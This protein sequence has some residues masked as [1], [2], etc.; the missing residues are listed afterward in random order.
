MKVLL[1][2]ATGFIGSAIL[3]QLIQRGDKVRVLVRPNSNQKNFQSQLI[4]NNSDTSR[5]FGGTGSSF[6]NGA[7]GTQGEFDYTSKIDGF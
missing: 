5:T 7:S 1:T 6:K 2:G 3:R 4:L